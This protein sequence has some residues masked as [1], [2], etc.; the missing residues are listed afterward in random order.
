MK[1]LKTF[2]LV[3]L[4]LGCGCS[5]H[6][7]SRDDVLPARDAIPDKPLSQTAREINT[8]L[9]KMI[10]SETRLDRVEGGPGKTFDYYFTL[11]N[12][13]AD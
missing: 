4:L 8:T 1:E 9:P 13:S 7:D 11:G 5:Q 3:A 12:T 10:D 2:L 6:E